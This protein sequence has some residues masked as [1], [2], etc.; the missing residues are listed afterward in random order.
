MSEILSLCFTMFY[1]SDPSSTVMNMWLLIVNVMVLLVVPCY[2]HVGLYYPLAR[3]YALDFL[4]NARTHG[5]CGMAPG[6]HVTCTTGTWFTSLAKLSSY[7]HHHHHHH[8]GYHTSNFSWHV[9][10]GGY[11]HNHNH[12][13]IAPLRG[14]FRGAREESIRRHKSKEWWSRAT[15]ERPGGFSKKFQKSPQFVPFY[16]MISNVS[17]PCTQA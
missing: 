1:R 5:P 6:G 11:S 10:F 2:G 8:K 13:Y 15:A 12:I 17:G 16:G 9:L 7:S 4:D 14:G 3:T